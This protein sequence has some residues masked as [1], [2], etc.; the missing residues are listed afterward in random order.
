[1]LSNKNKWPKWWKAHSRVGDNSGVC[2]TINLPLL[3]NFLFLH[4]RYLENSSLGS[5]A[6]YLKGKLEI[7]S[8]HQLVIIPNIGDAELLLF[9]NKRSRVVF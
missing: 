5:L 9:Y 4:V 1:M 7:F 6:V 8:V 2:V 3:S